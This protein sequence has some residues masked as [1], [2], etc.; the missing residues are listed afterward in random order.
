MR[1]VTR[2]NYAHFVR[3]LIWRSI[4]RDWPDRPVRLER[5]M[6]EQEPEFFNQLE[7]IGALKFE[8]VPKV[9]SCSSGAR[10]SKVVG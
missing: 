3:D 4:V 10:V 5:W 6:M 2:S 1:R 7:N 9:Q 8:V